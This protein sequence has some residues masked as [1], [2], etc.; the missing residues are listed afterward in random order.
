M[1]DQIIVLLSSEYS[2]SMVW[3]NEDSDSESVDL[4]T[5]NTDRLFT[6]E[7]SKRNEQEESAVTRPGF[8][9]LIPIFLFISF[10]IYQRFIS[11]TLHIIRISYAVQLTGRPPGLVFCRGKLCKAF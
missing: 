9:V 7:V 8:Q 1:C 6:F 5:G 4:G 2:A 10:L 3:D 11:V